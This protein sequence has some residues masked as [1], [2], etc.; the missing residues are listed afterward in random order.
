MTSSAPDLGA[1]DR[2]SY[3][4][5]A[6]TPGVGPERLAILLAAF[7]SP[8]GALVAPL[9]FLGTIPGIS[10]SCARAI[11]STRRNA[12]GQLLGAVERLGAQVLLPFDPEYPVLLHDIPS[13]PPYLIVAG[14]L[15]LLQRPAVAIVGSRD[16]SRYGGEVCRRVALTAAAGGVVVVSGL[17]RGLD[18]VA[19]QAA[20]DAGGG[21][22]GVLG[23][24][25]D[26]VYP[27]ANQRL[28]DAIRQEGLL[29]SEFL[30]GERPTPG[31]FPRRNRLISGLARVTVLIE[32]SVR[33]GA[34]ITAEAALAQGREVMVVPGPIT[35]AT[36]EGTNGLIRD[37][38]AP[39]I[40]PSDV[41][42]F[43]P[44]AD[45]VSSDRPTPAGP[46]GRVLALLRHGALHVDELAGSLA[47]PPGKLLGLLGAME[48]S[49]LVRQDPALVFS[50]DPLMAVG[51]PPVR[52]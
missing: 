45:G 42:R 20:L 47:L 31:S 51:R 17:A 12:G 16:H 40:H 50:I 32:A 15:E 22:I 23:N 10:P 29:V 35:S 34:L 43:Y 7:G 13:P 49:G 38:A 33:S 11:R 44:E 37:G 9:A 26:V 27:K 39:L 21:T 14:R 3:L 24:G 19:H 52:A 30:P 28:Y 46:Q 48:L 18:A 8:G 6:L 25:I 36:A 4:T 1:D 41:L 5:L 2:E